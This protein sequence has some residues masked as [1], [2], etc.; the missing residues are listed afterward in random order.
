MGWDTSC[1]DWEARL[2]AGRVPIR[3][4]ELFDAPRDKALRC[5]KRLRLPDVRDKP[6]METAAGPW[7]FS[8]VEALF[9]S[10]DPLTQRRMIQELFLLVP[11]KNM[12]ST[13]AAGIMVTALIV[14]ERPEAE[15]TLVAPTKEVTGISYKQ[16]KGIIKADPGLDRLFQIRDHI[17][18]IQHRNSGAYLQIKAADTDVITGT[19]ATGTLVDETHVF[20]DRANAA[21]IFVELRGALA[22]RPDGFLIQITTQS[23]KPPAGLF[24]QELETARNVRDGLINLPLLPVLYELP[25]KIQANDGW[26]RRQYWH[27]VNPNMGRSVDE[28]FLQNQLLKAEQ[29]GAEAMALLASQHFNV[30]VGLHLR[31]DRW[32]GADHWLAAADPLLLDL[33]E[34]IDRSE[35]AVM[36][37]DGGGLDDLFGACVLGRCKKTREWLAW[38]HA[39]AHPEVMSRK[40]I[41]PTLQDFIKDGTLTLCDTATQ[42]VEEVAD[43]AERIRDAGL[44][45]E[46]QAVGL[47]PM[48]VAALVDELA[49]RKIEGEQVCGIPQGYRLSGAVW[50]TERKL[51]DGTLRH[52]GQPLMTWCVGNAKAEQRGNAV[53]ITK[54]AAGKAKIDPL[55]ALFNAVMLMSRNPEAKRAPEYQVFF[56]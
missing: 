35:V 27:I 34:L 23:K 29:D 40:E 15:F 50:G 10:L 30:Q 43:I 1:L 21:D 20:S 54:Q 13:G 2:M 18:T 42:D 19:K 36:G 17:K 52:G 12:K 55:M 49:S 25:D 22:A 24:K 32:A 45:P 5:F 16:A 33:Q 4:L 31:G 48:G 9:G 47:D 28:I 38:C 8:L 53:L 14:N 44:F 56:A 26:K 11:K 3:D 39:W 37:A 51:K 46:K 7:F 41:A 6:R